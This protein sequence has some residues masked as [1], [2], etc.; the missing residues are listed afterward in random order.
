MSSK[1]RTDLRNIL[2]QWQSS[3]LEPKEVLEWS[4]ER[5][6]S[7][8]LQSGDEAALSILTL[9]DSLHV[10]LITIDDVPV[11][12]QMLELPPDKEEEA[13]HLLE[14]HSERIVLEARKMKYRNHPLY[15]LFCND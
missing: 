10:N 9:L 5:Y 12:L 13:L 7:E 11:F 1:L 8:D 4:E 15:G 6:E 3:T 2:L 14:Q